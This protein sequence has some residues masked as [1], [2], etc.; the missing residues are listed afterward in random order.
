MMRQHLGSIISGVIAALLANALYFL[1]EYGSGKPLEPGPRSLL[2]GLGVGLVA[3]VLAALTARL[4]RNYVSAR[5][6]PRVEQ[7]VRAGLEKEIREKI[8]S[9]ERAQLESLTGIIRIYPN[10]TNC[11]KEILEHLKTSGSIRI[12]IQIGKSVLSG[13]GEKNFYDYLGNVVP[14][15]ATVKILHASAESPYL[16]KERAR[17]RGSDYDEWIADLEF[18]KKKVE[19][20]R[21]RTTKIESRQHKEG[22]VWR[23]FIFDEFAYVQAYLSDRHTGET[24]PV[25]KLSRF[26]SSGERSENPNSLYR[27]F[28]RYFDFKWDD[29]KPDEIK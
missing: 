7:E 24:V 27:A 22:Y 16:S 23:L 6:R 11:Q 29:Y 8:E 19:I 20:L 10:F 28:L 4:L 21:K 15:N 3:F 5:L 2:I 17:E 25:L 26:L 9:C 1:I 18:A 12:F 14:P 13:T